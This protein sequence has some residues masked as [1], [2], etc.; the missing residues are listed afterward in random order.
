MYSK[1]QIDNNNNHL[2]REEKKPRDCY[3]FPRSL[4]SNSVYPN[5]Y[6]NNNY[7]NYNNNN[8][9]FIDRQSI[10]SRKNNDK[11]VQNEYLQRY[12]L[13]ELQ[14][15]NNEYVDLHKSEIDR[16][17]DKKIDYSNIGFIRNQ[18]DYNLNYG[19]NDFIDRPI[20]TR[21]EKIDLNNNRNPMPRV[22]GTPS[23][24]N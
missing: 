17:F 20:D 24:Y 16:Q 15:I 6:D 8:L 10:N 21:R 13:H 23:E 9:N 22:L 4:P 18:D 7:N 11:P 19:A 3:I 12:Q 2:I 14:Q 1:Y 5:N